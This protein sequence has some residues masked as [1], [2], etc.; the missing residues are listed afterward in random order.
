MR[1]SVHRRCFLRQNQ[2]L[3]I[4]G[5]PT[6]WGRSPDPGNG[7]RALGVAGGEEGSNGVPTRLCTQSDAYCNEPSFRTANKRTD[8]KLSG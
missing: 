8:L 2:R 1:T 5:G 3:W 4:P 6:T 7:S